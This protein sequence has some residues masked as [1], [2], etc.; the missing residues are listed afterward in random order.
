M[1]AHSHGR[2]LARSGEHHRAA[3]RFTQARDLFAALAARPFLTRYRDDFAGRPSGSHHAA[4]LPLLE[5][6]DREHD[7][8]LLIGR[9]LTNR[10]IAAWLFISSK[11]VEY[12]LSH[13][14][15][16]LSLSGRRQLR[17][18]VQQNGPLGTPGARAASGAGSS[19]SCPPLRAEDSRL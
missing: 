17:N 7:I 13:V 4:G 18:I 16:K 14:Y 1:L 15:Q 10:E 5:L 9:G 6:T 2:L 11:T 8:S 12:H 3:A 19:C